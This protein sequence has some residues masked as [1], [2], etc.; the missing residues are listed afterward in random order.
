MIDIIVIGAGPA[1]IFASLAS[2]NENT[3][4]R[5]LE[6]NSKIG[7]KLA[8][9]GKGRCNITNDRDISE[10][11]DEI[12]TNANFCYSSFYSYPNIRLIE[13]FNNRGLKT[14]FER[15]GRVFP[16]SDEAFDVIDLLRK[17]LKNKGIEIL[18]DTTVM[19]IEKRDKFY[20]DIG[21]T[22]PLVADKLIIATG[23]ASY[24]AT[25]S[26]GDGYVFAK[27][28]GH[29]I[30]EIGPGL[31]PIELKDSFVKDLEG[32]SL[33][34]ISLKTKL[35]KKTIIEE[36]GDL[37]FTRTGISGPIVLKTSSKLD[38][39]KDYDL[40]IDLKPSLSDQNLDK[41]IQRDFETY[42]NKDFSNSLKDLT[43]SALIPLIIEKS[44]IEPSKKVHQITK[45]ER[46]SLVDVFK[47]FPLSYKGLKDIKYGI[48][49]R[50]GIDVK[51][52]NPST[53]ESKLVKDLYF[54]G[55]IIDVDA[56]TGGYNLQFAFSSGYLAGIACGGKN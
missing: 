55:E 40:S 19:S 8:I 54:A 51:D 43:I 25:G 33:K 1:G 34:N 42:T 11:F 31:V 45:V 50:G 17:E 2:K 13:F 9:T 14:K 32:V 21:K 26:T 30:K 23:G 20:V 18:T 16:T 48:I 56:N 39:H 28:F 49:T 24:P 10:F 53:M 29:E 38:F 4:V 36:F 22:K 3:R 47:N 52:I 27:S 15:G 6:K 46:K 7:R 5:I 12:N 44:N 37:V 41:R 35:G